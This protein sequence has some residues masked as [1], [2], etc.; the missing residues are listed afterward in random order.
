MR[1]WSGTE[2]SGLRASNKIIKRQITLLQASAPDLGINTIRE[3]K[4]GMSSDWD[5]STFNIIYIIYIIYFPD[6]PLA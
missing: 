1:G 4:E 5:Q 6:I 2:W 3:S